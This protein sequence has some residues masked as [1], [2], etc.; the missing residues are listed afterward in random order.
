MSNPITIKYAKTV[1]KKQLNSLSVQSLFVLNE[2][3]L[4]DLFQV[5][6]GEISGGGILVCENH[7]TVY[8]I[9]TA[10]VDVIHETTMVIP[11]NIKIE[12]DYA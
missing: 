3:E 11:V 8:N 7:I 2:G 9:M 5:I 12:I 6:D 1:N 4:D 10:A